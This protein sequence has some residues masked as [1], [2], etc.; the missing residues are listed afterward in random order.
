MCI[1]DVRLGR[2]TGPTETTVAVA[3]TK[4]LLVPYVRERF[5]LVISAPTTNELWLSLAATAAAGV[6]LRLY[7]GSLPLVLNVK[8]HGAFVRGPIYANI[9][10]VGEN[11]TLWSTLL[12]KE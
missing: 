8:D 10:T 4:V 2:E 3:T 7:P 9:T 11:I 1:E 12:E 5:S 6:G